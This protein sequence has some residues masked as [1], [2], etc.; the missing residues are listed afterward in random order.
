MIHPDENPILLKPEFRHSKP[1]ECLT[2]VIAV[3]CRDGVVLCADSQ[4]STY[5]TKENVTKILPVSF[6]D[7]VNEHCVLGCA[8]ITNYTDLLRNYVGEA[9]YKHGQKTHFDTLRI[10]LAG[11]TKFV[12][13]D[14]REAGYGVKEDYSAFASAIF[15]GYDPE[16]DRTQIYELSPPRPPHELLAPYRTAIGTGGLFASSLFGAA[17]ELMYWINLDWTKLSTKL[18]SQFC[19]LVL[20]LV[21]TKD[22]HSGMGMCF[23]K[24][25]RRWTKVD[26]DTILPRSSYRL[27]IFL[28]TL[29]D[30][31]DVPKEKF[32]KLL[33]MYDPD[34]ALLE[35]LLALVK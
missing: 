5:W 11:F 35:K 13:E 7:K 9:F 32:L 3:R 16:K 33:K 23:Y 17:E 4:E 27:P 26:I 34:G 31:N 24:V 1:R 22:V 18:V 21:T 14:R 19:Y 2:A 6:E 8:G 20:G 10:A 30:G 12:N 29:L 28:G 25:D 15:V